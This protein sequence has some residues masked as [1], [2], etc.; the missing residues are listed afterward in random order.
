MSIKMCNLWDCWGWVCVIQKSGG[1]ICIF[2]FCVPLRQQNLFSK[3]CR[4]MKSSKWN[5]PKWSSSSNITLC[6]GVYC[7]VFLTGNYLVSASTFL[8]TEERGSNFLRQFLLL[9]DIWKKINICRFWD[10][11]GLSL[12]CSCPLPCVCLFLC[13]SIFFTWQICT[14]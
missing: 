14:I 3:Q 13:V 9:L 11:I 1:K 2:S 7:L 4:L 10:K 5:G 6:M 8:M 12:F